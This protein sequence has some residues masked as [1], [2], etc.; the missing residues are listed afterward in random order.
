MAELKTCVES[1][2]T[3]IL[4]DCNEVF[5]MGVEDRAWIFDKSKI[6]HDL[7]RQTM[8]IS[9]MVF[10]DQSNTGHY[11]YFPAEDAASGIKVEDQ[12]AAIGQ[13]YNK[14]A[15]LILMANTPENA[16][17]IR[18]L[19]SGRYIVVFELRHKADG[20]PGFIVMGAENGC[21]G[22]DA[23]WDAYSEDTQGGF[24]INLVEKNATLP[25]V[26]LDYGDHEQTRQALDTLVGLNV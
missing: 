7:N 16:A 8:T 21:K 11:I 1:L 6:T 14:T 10:A 23:T 26:F 3:N 25:Q 17:A 2:A 4:N 9:Y 20:E 19:K 5:G 12:N 18:A 13:R 24:A 15:P 22:Q